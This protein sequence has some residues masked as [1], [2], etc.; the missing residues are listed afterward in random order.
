MLFFLFLGTFAAFSTAKAL[1]LI[2]FEGML[3]GK[4][5][6]TT[7]GNIANECTST[8]LSTSC[9]KETLSQTPEH[10]PLH[11]SDNNRHSSSSTH[12]NISRRSSQASQRRSLAPHVPQ[13]WPFHVPTSTPEA[14]DDEPFQRNGSGSSFT[15][16]SPRFS[17]SDSNAY[18]SGS[19]PPTASYRESGYAHESGFIVP[20][21]LN[22]SYGRSS[23]GR[24]FG[25][26]EN[27]GQADNVSS[28]SP[29]NFGSKRG[30]SF[31]ES[32]TAIGNASTARLSP[33]NSVPSGTTGI[34]IPR[35]SLSQTSFSFAPLEVAA[36][37]LRNEFSE[38]EEWDQLGDAR[39]SD[40]YQESFSQSPSAPSSPSHSPIVSSCSSN[41]G[42]VIDAM[43]NCDRERAIEDEVEDDLKD[44]RKSEG[45]ESEHSVSSNGRTPPPATRR[46]SRT[47][48][49]QGDST[50][51]VGSASGSVVADRRATELIERL[52][53]VDMMM[54]ESENPAIHNNPLLSNM[55][56]AV[57][58][59]ES[60]NDRRR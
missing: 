48:L 35:S 40:G 53:L 15:L 55:P 22:N 38:Q 4:E 19:S 58:Y 20:M 9:M 39:N 27:R 12:G 47:L 14:E 7:S 30:N 59:L 3:G 46:S 41:D 33:F 45:V 31:A 5:N 16:S 57:R 26:L 6:G 8:S 60:F 13:T 25:I 10:T 23:E 44:V 21:H 51:S 56:S 32:S 1:S 24:S 28:E 54:N 52:V 2:L 29:L 17:V 36:P 50:S 42:S 11:S 43:E 49:L 37:I 18:T 34:R